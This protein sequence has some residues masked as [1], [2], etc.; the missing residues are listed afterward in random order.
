MALFREDPIDQLLPNTAV[1][2]YLGK[3]TGA[4]SIGS[5]D[6]GDIIPYFTGQD[7]G[8]IQSTSLLQNFNTLE[9]KDGSLIENAPWTNIITSSN[10]AGTVSKSYGF[11]PPITNLSWTSIAPFD[12]S[13]NRL[14]EVN[15]CNAILEASTQSELT[16]NWGWFAITQDINLG[17][18]GTTLS[19]PNSFFDY[20]SGIRDD[21]SKS[22]VTKQEFES[23]K[24]PNADVNKSVLSVVNSIYGS[25]PSAVQ[26]TFD[27]D[28][29]SFSLVGAFVQKSQDQID[30]VLGSY[31][32]WVNYTG[33]VGA[34]NQNALSGIL[35]NYN[36]ARTGLSFTGL[37]DTPSSLTA[38][39]YLKVNSAGDGFEFADAGGGGGGDSSGC[40]NTIKIRKN[41][42]DVPTSDMAASAIN[43]FRWRY[44]NS[45]GSW[46]SWQNAD[47]SVITD[48]DSSTSWQPSFSP[49]T[50][51]QYQV[52]LDF[53][54]A[55]Y[56][57]SIQ[58]SGSPW[59]GRVSNLYSTQATIDANNSQN[60][61]WQLTSNA[62]FPYLNASSN[63]LG[64]VTDNAISGAG[65]PGTQLSWANLPGSG[66]IKRIRWHANNFYY[67]VPAG[68]INPAIQDIKLAYSLT[69]PSTP[70]YI[71]DRPFANGISAST[72]PTIYLQR[73]QSYT[74]DIESNGNPFYIKTANSAGTSDLFSAGITNN[75]VQEGDLTFQVPYDAPETLYYV[76]SNVSTLSG[77]IKILAADGGSHGGGGSTTGV[78]GAFNIGTGSGVF[79]GISDNDLVFRTIQAGPNVT[80]DEVG[81]GLRITA[82]VTVTGG[83]VSGGIGANPFITGA[84]NFYTEVPDQ[85]IL[86]YAASSATTPW[87]LHW[88]DPTYIYYR[89]FEGD[90][91]ANY[92]R[93]NNDSDGSFY[94]FVGTAGYSPSLS[95]SGYLS[96]GRAVYLGGNAAGGGG[97]GVG[98]GAGGIGSNAF[99]S[100]ASNFYKFLP[101]GLVHIA[102]N[103][104]YNLVFELIDTG[105]SYTATAVRYK[106]AQSAGTN[107][108]VLSF[109]NDSDG[110]N[111]ATSLGGDSS[112]NAAGP[113]FS[114]L[115]GYVASGRAV[116][117]GGGGSG[118]SSSTTGITGVES[119]GAGSALASGVS[120]SDLYLKSLVGGT[121]VTLSSDDNTITINAAG[122]GGG[123][124]GGSGGIG[125]NSFIEARSNFY[126]GIPDQIILDIGDPA[127][128]AIPYQVYNV[129]DTKIEYT[130][131]SPSALYRLIFDNDTTG[132]Y[133]SSSTATDIPEL[134]LSGYIASGRAVY[135]G[136]GGG[137]GGGSSSVSGGINSNP[138]ISALSNFTGILPDS[139]ILQNPS[140]PV[141][142]TTFDFYGIETGPA[143]TSQIQYRSTYDDMSYSI[144]FD[145]DSSGKYV[146]DNSRP[147]YNWISGQP[148]CLQD[149]IDDGLAVFAGGG[150]SSS[151][152]SSTTGITGATNLGAGSGLISGISDNDLQVKSLV[153]GT[154]LQITGDGESLYLNVTGISAG[155]GG[156]GGAGSGAGNGPGTSSYYTG[157][158]NFYSD[159]PDWVAVKGA[160]S[161]PIY[162][163][164]LSAFDGGTKF[165]YGF[166]ADSAAT[167]YFYSFDNDAAG[168]F[169]SSSRWAG[170]AVTAESP[171]LSGLLASGRAGYMGGG[172]GSSSS[173]CSGIL[174]YR[175]AFAEGT[176]YEVNDFVTYNGKSY[177]ATAAT[178]GFD[179]SGY[180]G[181]IYVDNGDSTDGWLA[182][183]PATVSVQTL[184]GNDTLKAAGTAATTIYV[185]RNLDLS[186]YTG[187]WTDNTGD[188]VVHADVLASTA[189]PHLI[190]TYHPDSNDAFGFWSTNAGADNPPSGIVLGDDY[191][192]SGPA[193]GVVGQITGRIAPTGTGLYIGLRTRDDA[194][195]TY[196]NFDNIVIAEDIA[197][198]NPWSLLAGEIAV[199]N[200][201]SAGGGGGGSSS[202]GA[203]GSNSLYSGISNFSGVLPDALIMDWANGPSAG[204]SY[205]RYELN[206]INDDYIYYYDTYSFS[207]I[208]PSWLKFNNDVSGTYDTARIQGNTPPTASNKPLNIS[209]S[210][211][212]DSGR[213]VYYGGSSNGGG[214]GGGG[215]GS[216]ASGTGI[217]NSAF[218]EER[219]NYYARIPDQIIF[220]H[221]S[222][223]Y[224][225]ALY[226]GAV[227][228]GVTNPDIVYNSLTTSDQNYYVRFNN[229][230]QGTYNSSLSAGGYP[231][232]QISGM[233]SSDSLSGLV[234][235][236]ILEP[237]YYNLGG[238]SA[239]GSS[240]ESTVDYIYRNIATN[241]IS[242]LSSKLPDA[243]V[244]DLDYNT[245]SS[246]ES[247]VLPLKTVQA[248]TNYIYYEMENYA[249]NGRAVKIFNDDASGTS[250]GGGVY[251]QGSASQDGTHY[252]FST[253]EINRDLQEYIDSGLAI[254][255]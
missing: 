131:S 32:D 47:L 178:N 33:A 24:F 187:S 211:F 200:C 181:A 167:Y 69:D 250:N 246:S 22:L 157:V 184:N 67:P 16:A 217:G 227:R 206:W 119:L 97:G 82:N 66:T 214:G 177:I 130:W 48:G 172:S 3:I 8:V 138:A 132:A 52:E 129:D 1:K 80:I 89:N 108:R 228:G 111:A 118:S 146:S 248:S 155:G 13:N 10:T 198:T 117:L 38:D 221:P 4:G 236:G 85:I 159:L 71:V 183:S 191:S 104:V 189:T 18:P 251:A 203:L 238:S 174:N 54:D 65:V 43:F 105:S 42:A 233:T 46:G 113:N 83:S 106:D 190:F 243:I 51:T 143:A 72:N 92:L 7:I 164:Y 86:D 186:S 62:H 201:G 45:F 87:E 169:S 140:T 14:T 25:N 220:N 12:N 6:A 161:D 39:K 60:N 17:A 144:T 204:G 41:T 141:W 30:R 121:N 124:A 11:L 202:N 27:D 254:Y 59:W 34:V 76:S 197:S 240:S 102:D 9:F 73:G 35:E 79:S 70:T 84:S 199:N 158:S 134:S 222:N 136:G 23:T 112:F 26:A 244:V 29:Y 75:G 5:R 226:L 196:A 98:S 176:D 148:N 255:Y 40:C 125:G 149:M 123:G 81:S 78:T 212:I 101:D 163:L 235:S 156:G 230:A 192:G 249:Y 160:Q 229:D 207:A 15:Y 245:T 110:S 154:N 88:I 180:K 74:F 225:T 241:R 57:N 77:M 208:A 147:P 120:G 55:I 168:T 247:M 239:G 99:V 139:I 114:T 31:Y 252:H 36:Y 219:S 175:G 96:S 205:Y 133:S 216:T 188:Y 173:S 28:I 50:H 195:N 231:I 100:G 223:G 224:T 116:Y 170:V 61:A 103:R 165:R 242:T 128:N 64:N 68:T 142:Y 237:V 137:G 253:A 171:S 49:S 166:T 95:L 193:A 218:F 44:G 56:L 127:T 91:T 2:Y 90:V 93:L 153:G 109:R 179:P 162:I 185:G 21:P 53:N 126:T 209:I 215:G 150:G 19:N 152:S 232:A 210:E 182:R 107:D 63:E 94:D 115:S 194:P 151:S 234:E 145:N 20:I 37:S 58:W 213:A 122:G 135:L